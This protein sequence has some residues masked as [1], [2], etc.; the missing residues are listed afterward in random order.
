MPS[1]RRSG[2]YPQR[3]RSTDLRRSSRLRRMESR[4]KMLGFVVRT[5]CRSTVARASIGERRT[6]LSRGRA[7][8]SARRCV[9]CVPARHGASDRRDL[10]S[11]GEPR[12]IRS[13]AVDDADKRRF[14]VDRTASTRQL[15]CGARS[16]P[17]DGDS[18][19]RPFNRSAQ[20][21][22]FAGARGVGRRAL[23]SAPARRTEGAAFD[24][25][26]QAGFRHI[27]RALPLI[28]C[29]ACS[30]GFR[31]Q[32]GGVNAGGNYDWDAPKIFLNEV[33]GRW[34]LALGG[35]SHRG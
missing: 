16:E 25:P 7:G 13:S 23:G 11:P 1:R 30:A 21:S 10:R 6:T 26:G 22:G 35:G 4:T 19:L 12:F 9:Q 5:C 15:R 28:S 2:K 27:W 24:M 29:A 8:F 20:S 32:A 17:L 33:G 31:C 3:R 14:A 18:G 34:R